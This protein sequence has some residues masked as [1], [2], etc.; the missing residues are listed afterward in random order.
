MAPQTHDLI[1]KG[2]N[3]T[4]SC[5]LARYVFL[6]L[7][8]LFYLPSYYLFLSQVL[9][10]SPNHP[11][12]PNHSKQQWSASVP[13]SPSPPSSGFM[14]EWNTQQQWCRQGLGTWRD[15]MVVLRINT[16][17][18]FLPC[19]I[20]LIH[21]QPARKNVRRWIKSVTTNSYWTR[22]NIW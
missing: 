12:P 14:S 18:T 5:H 17:S 4:S 19:I 11:G 16:S 7:I 9:T 6:L 20:I 13:M 3:D 21:A 22:L 10:S 15:S 8:Y 1:A 2:P